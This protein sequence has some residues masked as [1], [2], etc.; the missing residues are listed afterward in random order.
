MDAYKDW[1]NLVQSIL[2]V[3]CPGMEELAQKAAN[4]GGRITAAY[5]T[6]GN[7]DLATLISIAGDPSKISSLALCNISLYSSLWADWYNQKWQHEIRMQIPNLKCEPDDN[8]S[9]GKI[10]QLPRHLRPAL[11]TILPATSTKPSKPT[12]YKA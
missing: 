9:E 12:A 11:F 6:A 1:K 4:L 3:N 8:S 7:A 10:H 2:S 5:I